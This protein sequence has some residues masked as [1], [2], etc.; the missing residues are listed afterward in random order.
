MKKT[1]HV[2]QRFFT[3]REIRI[4]L[5][6]I[7]LLSFL[8]AVV[9]M[10][11]IKGFGGTLEE[12]RIL[13]FVLIRVGYAIVVGLLTAIFTHR[14]I[15]PFERLRYE[16]G[17]ILSGDYKKRLRIRRH[18]DAYVRAFVADINKVLDLLEE[19]EQCGAEMQQKIHEELSSIINKMDSADPKVLKYKEALSQLRD[20]LSPPS[21]EQ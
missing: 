14:F 20:R 3:V 6:M 5:A 19:N 15:G 7:I 4:S 10:Y 17:V 11:L 21:V 16:L 9:F 18:D 13:A 2:K 8:S 12:H 1:P